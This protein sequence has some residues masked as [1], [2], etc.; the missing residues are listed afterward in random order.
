MADPKFL[1]EREFPLELKKLISNIYSKLIDSSSKGC[2][3]EIEMLKYLGDQVGLL[4]Y[5]EDYLDV[6][7]TEFKEF[8]YVDVP[9]L[10]SVIQWIEEMN[11][12]R[13]PKFGSKARYG[14]VNKYLIAFFGYYNSIM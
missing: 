8:D 7:L 13:I 9:D 6:E 12:Q 10:K 4:N 3:N 2:N 5:F 1:Y 14:N 11:N